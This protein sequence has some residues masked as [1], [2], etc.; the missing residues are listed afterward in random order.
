MEKNQDSLELEEMKRQIR[1]LK[2]KLAQETIISEKMIRQSTQEKLTYINR[3]KRT[4]YILIPLAL[5]YCNVFF[6]MLN[7]SWMF[8]IATSL[9]LIAA[10]LYQ[11]YS[12]KGVDAKEISAGNLINISQALVR[13]I[14]LEL[15]WLYFGIPFA[16]LWMVW[17]VLESY[18]KEEGR[19]ICFGGIIGF[20]AGAA[21]GL[22]HLRNVRRKAKEAIRNIEEYTREE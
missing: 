14:R 6:S 4:V 16:L 1:L 3:K 22:Q 15:R 7:Y 13:M 17:F 9:F 10:C 21:A 19:A 12:H 20:I 8:C 11:L 18:P 2:D 5:I